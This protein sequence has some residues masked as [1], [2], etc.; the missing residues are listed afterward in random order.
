MP[1]IFCIFAANNRPMGL[2]ARIRSYRNIITRPIL[3]VSLV[4]FFN[5]IGSE[6]LYPVMPVFLSSVG[7]SVV[8]IG[9]LE[10]LA[11]ATAGISKGYFGNLSDQTGRRVPFIRFGY[12]LS[13]LAKPLLVA[14]TWVWWIFAVRT[15]DRLGKGIRSSARDALLSDETSPENKGKVFGFH[16]AFDTLGAAIGPSIALLYL[17]V[18]PEDYKTL[19][20]LAIIPGV[21]SVLLTF[22]LKDKQRPD[23]PA[24]SRTGFLGFLKYFPKASKDYKLLIAGLL[25][26]ALFNSSDAFLLLGLK[27]SGLDDVRMIGYY[28][29]YNLVFALTAFPM[30]VIADKAGLHKTLI[31]GILVFA[32]VYT[33]MGMASVSVHFIVLFALYGLYAA[34]TDGVSKA[35][36]TN[37]CRREETATGLGLYNAL[38]SIVTLISSSLAGLVW[39]AFGAKTMFIIAGTG[40]LISALYLTIILRKK[41]GMKTG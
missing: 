12:L 14:F 10:G 28:I 23:R 41:S 17:W 6:L 9:L 34:A 32:V 24:K 19:F 36:I 13:A 15:A 26:F 21:G 20:L 38:A 31:A 33:G 4:S 25:F 39:F 27:E 16:R 22:F 37:H 1:R 5:D 7:F 8:L 35:L 18:N 3:L 29:F 2:K 30:G 11:E 40:A